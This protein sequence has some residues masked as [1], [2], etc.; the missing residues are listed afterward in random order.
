MPRTRSK[1]PRSRSRRPL[2]RERIVRVA[3]EVFR[4][5]GYHGATLDDIAKLLR[6]TKPALYYHIRT[7]EELLTEIYVEVVDIAI[8]R[9]TEVINSDLPITEK[10]AMVLETNILT[11][12][13][14]LP[15]FTVFFQE[16]R[17]LSAEKHQRVNAKKLL[18]TELTEKLY[19]EGVVAG[20][21]RDVDPKLATFSLFG[22]GN[23]IYQWFN[24]A[25]RLSS[26]DVAQIMGDLAAHGYL[27]R[28]HAGAAPLPPGPPAG[29]E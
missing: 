18:Y 2:T 27:L 25:G 4:K 23:W 9:L 16:K 5:R 21:F 8:R 24:P 14:Y 10:F 26:R 13:E 1:R 22:M 11:V 29:R 19:H 17:E 3:S 6:V 28:G 12:A 7:K 15:I 20:V